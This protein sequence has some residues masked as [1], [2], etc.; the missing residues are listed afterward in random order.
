M[1]MQIIL[2]G[3]AESEELAEKRRELAQLEAE[4]AHCE[5]SLA[6][7]RCELAAFERPYVRLG[8]ALV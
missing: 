8:G 6:S 7:L 3:S 1:S 4:L 5:L 2:S